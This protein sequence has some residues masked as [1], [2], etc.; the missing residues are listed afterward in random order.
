M[1]SRIFFGRMKL[2]RQVK[3]VLPEL[4]YQILIKEKGSK[5]LSLHVREILINHAKNSPLNKKSSVLTQLI[6]R[7]INSFGPITIKK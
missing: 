1:A 3:T 5:T 6:P 4:E 7:K 2:I